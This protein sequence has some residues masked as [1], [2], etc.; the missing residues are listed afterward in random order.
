VLLIDEIDKAD[1]D[2]PNGLLEALGNDS[3]HVPYLSERIAHDGGDPPLVILTTNEE[4]DLPAAFLRRCL[5]LTLQLVTD[6][7]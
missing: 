2:V 1:S 3:I 4:R 6:S 5:V 7:T